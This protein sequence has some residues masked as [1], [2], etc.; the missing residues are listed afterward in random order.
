MVID[1]GACV[2]AMACGWHAFY[3][4]LFFISTLLAAFLYVTPDP[5]THRQLSSTT[6]SHD[7]RLHSCVPLPF[8]SNHSHPEACAT[9]K[10]AASPPSPIQCRLDT[11]ERGPELC[12]AEYANRSRLDAALA[13]PNPCPGRGNGLETRSSGD[14]C[15]RLPLAEALACLSAFQC[16]IHAELL[17]PVWTD[18]VSS[19]R[20]CSTDPSD[21]T[22]PCWTTWDYEP[23]DLSPFWRGILVGAFSTLAFLFLL[24]DCGLNLIT[25]ADCSSSSTASRPSESSEPLNPSNN[26]SSEEAVDVK[27]IS[28]VELELQESLIPARPGPS[29]PPA[30][31]VLEA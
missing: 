16:L 1:A 6:Y 10:A 30:P 22:C 24:A 4:G 19:N 13:L 9:I 14:T 18:L 27:P 17:R 15:D 3:A 31:L 21:R 25:L 28:S 29:A 12:A 2:W 26:P 8:E 7:Y 5:P 11:P 23:T 20:R